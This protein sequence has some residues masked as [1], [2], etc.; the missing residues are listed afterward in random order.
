MTGKKEKRRK[1][2][3][4]RDIQCLSRKKSPDCA[5]ACKCA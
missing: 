1:G 2:K 5:K 3:K 4:G